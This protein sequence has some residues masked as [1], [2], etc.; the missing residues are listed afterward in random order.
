MSALASLV[1]YGL[2]KREE[3]SCG[4]MSIVNCYNQYKTTTVNRF[5]RLR[6]LCPHEPCTT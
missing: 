3:A 2:K 1:M 6:D 5:L 4:E